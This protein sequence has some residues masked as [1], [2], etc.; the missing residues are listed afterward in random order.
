MAATVSVRGREVALPVRVRDASA[1][2]ATFLVDAAAAADLLPDGLVP[3]RVGP[4]R[5]PLTLVMVDYRD[6][7][8]GD[9]HEAAIQL[10]VT[11][12][13]LAN[14]ARALTDVVR[15]RPQTWTVAMPVDQ[16][17]SLA[18]GR[19]IWGFPK[20]LDD[21]RIEIGP[22]RARCVWRADGEHVLTF[23]VPRGT[24][25]SMPAPPLTA[26]TVLDGRLHRTRF[27]MTA[28]HGRLGFGGAEVELGT[29]PVA[30]ELARLGLPRRAVMTTW[31]DD[32]TA[33]FGAAVP[34]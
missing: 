19:E 14:H 30:K 13:G 6:N 9:Y 3:V 29:H 25:R 7:D 10:T 22:A 12:S 1:G 26:W 32:V 31:M 2:T 4:R 21:V 27:E 15:G 23:S 5:T 34:T 33:S 17:F 24:S 8:L 20:T 18:A 11:R 28:E 16:E